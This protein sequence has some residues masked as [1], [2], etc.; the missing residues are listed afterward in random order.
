MNLVRQALRFFFY[1]IYQPMAWSY[2]LVAWSVSLGRWKDWVLCTLPYLLEGPVLE[3]GHGPGYLQTALAAGGLKTFGL[4][5]SKQMGRL[6]QRKLR[7]LGYAQLI[8]RGRSQALPFPA[9]SFNR[10]VATFPSEYIFQPGTLAEV[11]RVL[12]PGGRLVIAPLAWITGSRPLDRAARWL[13]RVTGEAPDWDEVWLK[14]FLD[15]G[16]RLLQK[17]FIE[18]RGSRVLVLVFEVSPSL[19]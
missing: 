12:A 4:D 6:A 3:L 11:Q 5:F 9:A 10:L 18:L 13:F 14:P 8:A 16:F 1:L 15:C 19:G 7:K 17:D 2:D